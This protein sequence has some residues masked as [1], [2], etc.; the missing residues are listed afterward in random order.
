MNIG[1]IATTGVRCLGNLLAGNGA[2]VL[3]TSTA[4]AIKHYTTYNSGAIA[5]G[6]PKLSAKNVAINVLDDGFS[7]LAKSS[8]SFTLKSFWQGAKK[9]L[10][11]IP[12]KTKAGW[13]AGG[14]AALKA[15]K[16][17]TGT[18]FAKFAGATKGLGKGLGKA[19]PIIGTAAMIAF[20]IPNIVK[21]TKDKG[22]IAGGAVETAK[23]GVK[24][25]A[26]F[27]GAALAAAVVKGTALGAV[28]GPVG[29]LVGA[30]VGI[31]GFMLG[32]FIATKVVGKS[33]S[34]KKAEEQQKQ[35][36]TFAQFAQASQVA[37]V[38]QTAFTQ[39]AAFTPQFTSSPAFTPNNPFAVNPFEQ[40]P[41]P[42]N[43][44]A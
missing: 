15:G 29:M 1:S 7:A 18:T 40:N 11:G 13:R 44:T 2:K 36:Q 20:E 25:G 19:M 6:L 30:A 10:A 8:Q 27:A 22:L 31:A 39:Q 38:P 32:N 5:R 42:L 34:E 23:A 26:G 4:E 14:A 9:Q 43:Y 24:L 33:H 35:A 16:G 21:A 12:A 37:Q 28:G 41:Y 17:T 3:E